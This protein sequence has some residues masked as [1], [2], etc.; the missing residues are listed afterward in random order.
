M[1]QPHLVAQEPL[2]VPLVGYGLG[3][4]FLGYS[5]GNFLLLP[6][7]FSSLLDL[8]LLLVLLGLALL[9][10][11]GLLVLLSLFLLLL[12]CMRVSLR[13]PCVCDMERDAKR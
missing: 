10:L 12:C 11:G 7:G 4:L 9:S 2:L 1:T 13:R 6:L 8:D 3:S 5:G